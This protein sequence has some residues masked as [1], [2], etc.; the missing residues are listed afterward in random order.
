M[1]LTT[2]GS[3]Q[4]CYIIIIVLRSR[5]APASVE[6]LRDS[7]AKALDGRS[8]ASKFGELIDKHGRNDWLEPVMEHLGP[9]IQLQLNDMA[10]MLE[11]FSK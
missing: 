4:Y 7:V 8:T 6:S 9:F 11:V 2:D 10:N 3:S 5:Y 1:R